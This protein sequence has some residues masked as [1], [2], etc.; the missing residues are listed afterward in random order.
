MFACMCVCMHVY[1]CTW[2]E[3][4]YVICVQVYMQRRFA[5]TNDGEINYDLRL[6]VTTMIG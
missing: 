6:T 2:Y 3:Y 1:M 5:N 4:M